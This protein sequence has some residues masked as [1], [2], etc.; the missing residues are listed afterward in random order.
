MGTHSRSRALLS[1]GILLSAVT[2]GRVPAADTG[3]LDG[4]GRLSI[5]DVSH[6]AAGLEP[7]AGSME[8]FLSHP[9]GPEG[10]DSWFMA[11]IYLE[12]LRRGVSNSI[13]H[14]D[15]VWSPLATQPPRGTPSAAIGLLAP[16]PKDR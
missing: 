9:C 15:Q 14:W 2:W 11:M 10:T 5:A 12:S 16:S 4:D 3:D 6:L 7:A 13:P 8:G 1:A